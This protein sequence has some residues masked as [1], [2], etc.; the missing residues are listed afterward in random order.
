MPKRLFRWQYALVALVFA[1]LV[2][3]PFSGDAYYTAIFIIIA[4][5]SMLVIGLCLLMGYTG[6]VSLG[7]AAFYGM[8]AFISAILTVTYNWSPWLAMPLAA[9]STGVIAYLIGLPLLRLRGNYLAMGTLGM[10]I[11]FFILF[12]ELDQYTGGPSGLPG[13]PGLSV[14]GFS[15]DTD[16]RYYYLVWSVCAVMLLVSWNIIRSRTGRAL[17]AI[18]GSEAASEAVGIDV[19]QF[20]IKVFVLS[21]IF[22]SIAGSLYVHYLSYVSPNPFEFM[23]SIRL[24]VMAV[25]G[26]L[27]NIWGAVFGTGAV[28]M[29][30]QHLGT[31]GE[32]DVILFGLILVL[33]MIF[34]PR[35]LVPGIVGLWEKWKNRRT[36][37][38]A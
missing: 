15:F 6:Q 33:V 17:R 31:F 2:L 30:D 36:K 35:G 34:M 18:H 26:G 21:A 38:K 28:T 24:V 4:I 22:A 19:P 10:G 37:A 14:G 16:F 12:N 20:K 5:H 32:L 11:I 13:V 29:M 8:G 23:F 7:H 25:I 3:L 9:L 1:G 27:A